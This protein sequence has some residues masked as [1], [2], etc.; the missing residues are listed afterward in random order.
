[1]TF[2]PTK[3]EVLKAWDELD[4]GKPISKEMRIYLEQLENREG[5]NKANAQETAKWAKREEHAN[6][7]VSA[8]ERLYQEVT[9]KPFTDDQREKLKRDFRK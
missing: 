2:K 6:E 5:S 7:T 3:E 8:F 4:A 9:H 1:M